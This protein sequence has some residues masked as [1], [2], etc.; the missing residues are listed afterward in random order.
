MKKT[1]KYKNKKT[2]ID[3][4]KFDSIAEGKYYLK[5]KDDKKR[6]F[7][8]DFELQPRF[9]LQNKFK[10][11]FGKSHRAIQYKADFKVRL[12][13]NTVVIIDIKGFASSEAKLK[14][15]LFIKKYPS[16]ELRWICWDKNCGWIDYDKLKK[17]IKNGK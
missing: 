13:D 15:K 11:N 5:L 12:D 16:T 1:S 6:G 9:I 4:I 17:E 2:I 10:D 3:G 14:R 7:I 8:K